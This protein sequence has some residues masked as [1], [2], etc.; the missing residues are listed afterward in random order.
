M[1]KLLL[2][3]LGGLVLL[4]GCSSQVFDQQTQLKEATATVITQVAKERAAIAVVDETA[5]AFP[6]T[7][8][9]AYA[10]DPT[11]DFATTGAVAALVTKRKAAFTQLEAAHKQLEA[12]I[13]KLTKLSSQA[14]DNLPRTALTNAL[15]SLK[16]A[17]LDHKT[18]DAYYSEL[19]S[20]QTLFFDQVSAAPDRE[21]VD[22]ALS[23]LN[24]YASSLS[25][26]ADIVTANL[27]TVAAQAKTLQ[28]AINEM[29]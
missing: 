29:D 11:H 23:R 8:Q 6:S 28:K 25:Q 14:N 19:G 3:L 10:S 16:L 22:A 24:Q 17:K 4:A 27:E 5:S 2:W 9:K 13:T 21:T 1:K 15:D 12:A 7:F 20:A 18:F 26:Q